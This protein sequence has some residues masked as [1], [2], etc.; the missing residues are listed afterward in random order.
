MTRV[1]PSATHTTTFT[2]TNARYLASKVA[3]DLHQLNRFYGAPS[4]EWIDAYIEELAVLLPG[5]YVSS[6]DYGFQRNGSWL[7]VL[8][9]SVRSDGILTL[10]DRA[11]R[12]PPNVDVRGAEPKSFLRPSGRWWELSDSERQRIEGLLPFKRTPA[13]EPG[14]ANGIWIDDKVYSDAG[15]AL[16]RKVFTPR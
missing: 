9:Y 8:R 5:G 7:V 3:T 11:G 2:E 1:A 12:V 16:S 4:G 14:T 15:V 6:V 13:N 10:D